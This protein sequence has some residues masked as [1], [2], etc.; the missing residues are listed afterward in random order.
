MTTQQP[1]TVTFGA[2]PLRLEQIV[3]LAQRTARGVLDLSLIH[4]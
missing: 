4:I 2:Q 1:E 3:S